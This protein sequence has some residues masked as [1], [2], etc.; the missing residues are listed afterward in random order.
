MED[1][2]QSERTSK[3][4]CCHNGL[5]RDLLERQDRESEIENRDRGSRTSD[6]EIDKL[7][8][9]RTLVDRGDVGRSL[10]LN[11]TEHIPRL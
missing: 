5:P 10:W 6:R 3:L 9:S 8:N 1:H 4:F 11:F 7:K 2:N